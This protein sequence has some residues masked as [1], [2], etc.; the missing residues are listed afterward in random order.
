MAWC[1]ATARRR[2]GFTLLLLACVRTA[3]GASASR[4]ARTAAV[5]SPCFPSRR[6]PLRRASGRTLC[7]GVLRLRCCTG[8]CS[9]RDLPC[10][11]VA[12]ASSHAKSA[13]AAGCEY[14]TNCAACVADTTCGW[15]ARSAAASPAGACARSAAAAPS[16][17]R[18]R[19]V[20]QPDARPRAGVATTRTTQGATASRCRATTTCVL[21]A[22]GL[23]CG[24]LMRPRTRT[25]RPQDLNP[26]TRAATMGGGIGK[27]YANK[28]A[29]PDGIGTCV[30]ASSS[31]C[32]A[33]PDAARA[34]PLVLYTA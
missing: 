2:A 20:A 34:A 11:A 15:C 1:N 30:P 31:I 3:Y 8:M 14:Y 6:A 32:F 7:A 26:F 21:P 16:R 33:L 22:A 18:V 19:A 27:V 4:L 13:P 17:R 24:R 23:P 25:F 28:T 5:A 10:G 12:A 9:C 29:P